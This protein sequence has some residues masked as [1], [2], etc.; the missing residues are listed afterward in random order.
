MSPGCSAGERAPR[1]AGAGRHLRDREIDDVLAA[2]GLERAA[3]GWRRGR[4]RATPGATRGAA[5]AFETVAWR[6][7]GG[8]RARLGDPARWT[9]RWSPRG[10]AGSCCSAHPVLTCGKRTTPD[11]RRSTLARPAWSTST[12]AARSPSTAPAARLL[13]LCA[14]RPRL[15]RRLRAPPRGGADRRLRR[16][17]R[18]HRPR[19]GR[20]GVWLRG[21]ARGP[22]RK[23]GV[24]GIGVSRGVAMH[25]LALNCDVDLGWY[26]RSCRRDRRRGRDLASAAGPRRHAR[27]G[28]PAGPRAPRPAAHLGLLRADTGLRA[29]AEPGRAPKLDLVTP[30]GAW[31][32]RTRV[33]H[34]GRGT[35]VRHRVGHSGP[36]RARRTVGPRDD[37][38]QQHCGRLGETPAQAANIGPNGRKLLR[39][40]VRNA[41]TPIER[42]PSWI[43]TR[44]RTGPQY[45]ELHNLV[46]EGGLNTV[47]QQ[48]G[49][50]T[51][52]SAGR[53][54]RP[55]S[56]SAATSAR[57]AATSARSTPASPNPWTPTSPGASP[58]PCARWA[59]ATP[60]SPASPATTCPTAA[61]GSTPRPS[62]PS[63][64]STPTRASRT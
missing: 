8:L 20:S 19:P 27:R 22:E 23:V 45:K 26:D 36:H 58:S 5:P 52:S 57:G 17:W 41:E 48:A 53:T 15:R 21:D 51:S 12:A 43:K 55:R 50:P 54:A 64:G 18:D 61:P 46:K 28:R 35:R 37:L 40:E 44:A 34:P 29:A 56:S 38:S 24:I 9:P 1:G 32:R 6:R 60:R 14:C 11:E 16:P 30:G 63:T 3:L 39:L 10:P 25:G 49:C 2:A 33:G 59:C 42:K 62:T 7:R 31:P 4:T 13:P 47:C